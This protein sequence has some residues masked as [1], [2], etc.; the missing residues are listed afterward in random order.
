M[1]HVQRVAELVD[2]LPGKYSS[3]NREFLNFSYNRKMISPS[4]SPSPQPTYN[5]P[6]PTPS[7]SPQPT[8]N[9]PRPTP[10]PSRPPPNNFPRPSPPPVIRPRPSPPGRRYLPASVP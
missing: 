8:Y 2:N 9:Y 10:S 1:W 7:P 5:Y 6:S 4:T 3:L